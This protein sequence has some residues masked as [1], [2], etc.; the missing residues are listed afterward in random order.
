MNVKKNI[1]HF[2][3]LFKLHPVIAAKVSEISEATASSPLPKEERVN[4]HIGNPVEDERLIG[5]YLRNILSLKTN[6]SANEKLSIEQLLLELNWEKK[7]KNKLQFI[8]DTVKSVG[9]YMP[10]G[11]FN[12]SEPN[13]LILKF[14][15]WLCEDQQD[16]LEYDLG[17]KS[18]KREC[19][20]GSGGIWEGIRVFLHSLNDY[21]VNKAIVI[22]F[23]LELP[24]HFKNYRRIIFESVPTSRNELLEALR[25]YESARKPVY[26]LLGKLFAEDLRRELRFLSSDI[27]IFF[28]EANNAPNHLSLAREAKLKNRVLRIL[29]AEIFSKH[30]SESST[31]FFAGNHDYIKVIETVHFQLKGTPSASETALLN[32]LIDNPADISEPER[33]NQS[34][35]M[36]D[37]IDENYGNFS[38]AAAALNRIGKNVTELTTKIGNRL[39]NS[40]AGNIESFNTNSITEYFT[41][42]YDLLLTKNSKELFD[43][44]FNDYND[45]SFFKEIEKSFLSVFANQH[46]EYE[47][48]KLTVINGSSRTALGLL[49]FHCGI[50]EVVTVDLSWTYEHCF[51]KV[52]VI[53]LT[54]EFEIDLDEIKRTI[55]QKLSNDSNWNKKAA[56][57][58]NNP[59]NASGKIFRE[60]DLKNLIEWLLRKHIYIIDD[61]AYQNVL[62]EES[63]NG[64]QTIKQLGLELVNEGRLFSD[65]LNH[66]ITCHSVSKTDSFAG[67]RLAVAEILDEK[68]NAKFREQSALI[69]PNVMAQLLSYLFYRNGSETV[70]GYWLMRNR[71]FKERI[72]ALRSVVEKLPS[73]RNRFDI[74]ITSPEG[75]MYPRMTINNLPDGLSLDWLSSGL[76]A[77]GIG[78]VPLS[79]FSRTSKGFELARKSFRLTLGGKDNAAKLKTK[80]RRVLID[81]N[82]MIAEEQSKYKR[83]S[84]MVRSSNEKLSHHLRPVSKRWQDFEKE[85]NGRIGLVLKKYLSEYSVNVGDAKLEERFFDD[86]LPVR[87]SGYS[88][89]F[90]DRINVTNELTKRILTGS[91]NSFARHL[92]K[93]FYKDNLT[94]RAEAFRSRMYD[95]TVHPTQMYSYKLDLITQTIFEK[96]ISNRRITSDDVNKFCVNIV[97]EYFGKNV[98]I[99]SVQEG[100]ELICDLNSLMQ[101]EDYA[102][103]NS[104]EASNVFLSFWG[105]WDG[106]SR[107]S[108][109]GHRLVASAIVENVSRM[110]KLLGLLVSID[111]NVKVE[112]ELLNEIYGLP[113]KINSFWKLLNNITSLTNQ[114]E[115]RYRSVL[116]YSISASRMRRL[117]IKLRIAKD[118]LTQLW[119][120]NDSLERKMFSL[121][122]QRRDRLEYFFSLNKKLRKTL[123]ANIPTVLKNLDNPATAI[124]FGLY[125]D[126]L[127]RFVLTPRIH[128]K[129]ITAKDQFSIN[130]TVYNINEI[131]TLSGRYGNPGM[132][133]ALQVSMSNDPEALITLD[134]KLNNERETML[135]HNET[136][137]PQVWSVPLLEEI[138]TV[139]N[140]DKYLDKIWEYANYNRKVN[141]NTAERF[142]E[143]ICEIFIAGSDLSQQVGQTAAW[144][145]Y[146][147]ARFKTIKWLAEKGLVEKVRMKLGSGEPMQR[148]GGYY[149]E[150][151]GKPAFVSDDSQ[152]EV[153]RKYLKESTVKST[154]FAVSP[155]HGVFYGGDLRTLQSTISEKLRFLSLDERSQLLHHMRKSQQFY[156]DELISAS[157]TFVDTRL[158]FESHSRR[159]LERLTEG[160][161]DEVFNSFVELSRKNFSE[162]IYGTN[163]DV[164]GIH[165]ISYFISRTTPTLRDRPTV[166]PSSNMGADKGQRVLERIAS[167]LPLSK[168][169]SL[170][171]AIGHNRAQSMILG[172]NQLTTGLFRTLKEFS[173]K[174]FP[175]GEGYLLI[176]DRILPKLPVY[177][178]LQTTRIYQDINLQYL[179]KMIE[180]FPA[181]NTA[182]SKLQEDIEAM[183]EY[184]PLL[185]K[186]LLRRHGI[187]VGEFFDDNKFITEL[188][189]TLR[190]DLAVL[191]QSDLFNTDTDSILS[192]I[193]FSVSDDW[194]LKFSENMNVPNKVHYWR[195]KI[196]TLLEEPVFTQVKSFVELALALYTLSKDIGSTNFQL[197]SSKKPK[198]E[199]TLTYL[200]RGK[201]DDSMRQFLSAAV[202][203][204][205]RL[206]E[207]YVEIPIDIVRALKEVERILR[208]EEQA[209]NKKEQELLIFYILQIARRVGE[210]G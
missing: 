159:L 143:T 138:D 151:S 134:R 80:T 105:D 57:A 42:E 2:D 156:H 33:A 108:G 104:A 140:V 148:Q 102:F 195:E 146:R 61:L 65:D 160:T 4:F 192:Q 91:R 45:E 149:A 115:K 198:A 166:R 19:I 54:D 204:L 55:E 178:I 174:D 15:K 34:F 173:T 165:V 85:V 47:L 98:P 128:Q 199:T 144:S 27:P 97:E 190:P 112:R 118:P 88:R 3:E 187:S 189:P 63:L 145:L 43:K 110:S 124:Q 36:L 35:H 150:F 20:I 176:A 203:Y 139:E 169:G 74:T 111:R 68:L 46:P 82:R 180:A 127:K 182:M 117:G 14:H 205:T 179:Q 103:V 126:I 1:T 77:Q 185:Q 75:S 164:V 79:T 202:Q 116:P 113:D 123:Y 121:R 32:Y 16:P 119:Q 44:I 191:L 125:K 181:G 153:L 136:E 95:R 154:E 59:H 96:L 93:E 71:I 122:Q 83:K 208:I 155:L 67:A 66:L 163:E 31:I 197:T 26:I 130:T 25:K 167:T 64:P 135:R 86:Y 132:V 161:N 133:M 6:S 60:D 210:N 41:K 120:H 40:F 30:F 73:D 87:F 206:P 12:R 196:W 22:P 170:L 53:P 209:L 107:P 81:L 51:S 18:G 17:L 13:E 62:P 84:F 23:G 152:K 158:K 92:E 188:L 106:S 94:N 90:N 24:E 21:S 162:I 100:E 10:R 48:K 201:V 49:G 177:E 142:S 39:S 175:Q 137:L 147:E 114:L 50:E 29:S 89:Q 28:V 168:H 184:I 141:Q 7:E 129:L 99:N 200:L 58:L 172:I 11:G 38:G 171:R 101:T 56:V 78:L 69:A 76:A 8:Y 207:D 72:D 186:E 5:L 193:N 109:Q 37:E 52:T 9:P 70:N 131:N 183:H 157:E 194:K